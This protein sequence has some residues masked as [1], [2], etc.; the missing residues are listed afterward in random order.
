ML[1]YVVD[2]VVSF[3]FVRTCQLYNVIVK[4]AYNGN[5]TDKYIYSIELRYKVIPETLVG[6]QVRLVTHP[7]VTLLRDPKDSESRFPHLLM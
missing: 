1:G 3:K 6:G 7:Y 2:A 4:D 5:E